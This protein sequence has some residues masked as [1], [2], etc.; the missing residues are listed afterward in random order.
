[1]LDAIVRPRREVARL[2]LL[3]HADQAPE[4]LAGT[5]ADIARLNRIG[6]THTLLAHV[7]P[8][9]E[10]HHGPE[11]L[12]V[13]DLGTGAADIPAALVVWARA[14][15]WPVRVVGLD[16]QPGVLACAQAR[17]A[18]F[19]EVRLVAGEA[20]APP[21]RPGAVDLAICSLMLHHLPEA[22]VVELLRRMA[23]T[24]RLGFVVSD[25]RRSWAAW[26]GAW[27]LTRATS[28][29][30]ITLHD[31]PLSVRRAYTR[32]ELRHLAAAA[33]VP[34]VAWHHAIAFRVI[35]VYARGQAAR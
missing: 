3:D 21:V 6:P 24:A 12:T 28:R 7:A 29:N 15:G 8:F 1:M 34:E 5:L 23:E 14:R 35:G 9:F 27:L 2:E 4:E 19:P 18:A 11:P 13:L 20:V 22:A 26:A 32:A 33:G 16:V 25:L 10:G 31:G 30:R 17:A